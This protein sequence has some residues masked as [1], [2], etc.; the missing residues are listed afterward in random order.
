MA[1][2][3]CSDFAR[4]MESAKRESEIHNLIWEHIDLLF[5]GPNEIWS[6]PEI[7]DDFGKSRNSCVMPDFIIRQTSP[8]CGQLLVMEIKNRPVIFADFIQVQYYRWLVRKWWCEGDCT[9]NQFDLV[10][11]ILVG[12]EILF[13]P[14]LY[15]PCVNFW[16]FEKI[17]EEIQIEETRRE[18]PA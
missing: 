6:K 13:N 9:D 4:Y 15:D 7:L 1:K 11:G 18:N 14:N 12:P 17:M 3:S 5:P 10:L 2:L 8:V 16:S